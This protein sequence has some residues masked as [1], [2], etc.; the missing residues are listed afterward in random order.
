MTST[1]PSSGSTRRALVYT[2]ALGLLSGALFTLLILSDQFLV[3]LTVAT[4]AGEK[5][6]ALVPIIIALVFSFVH[7]AFTGRFWDALGLRA[8]A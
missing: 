8:R 7:G 6:Y 2:L 1:Q 3:E 5:S 4:R